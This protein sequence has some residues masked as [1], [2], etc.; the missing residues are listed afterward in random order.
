MT[1]YSHLIEILPS[2]FSAGDSGYGVEYPA[3]SPYVVAVGGT[4]LTL[5]SDNS[6]QSETV[7]SGTGSGCSAYESKPSFQSDTLCKKRT[8]VDV[9]AAADAG[10][11]TEASLVEM[12]YSVTRLSGGT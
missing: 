7:W 2:L 3:A 5:N 10:D 9:A 11:S 4:T 6:R 1:M 12:G 8:V